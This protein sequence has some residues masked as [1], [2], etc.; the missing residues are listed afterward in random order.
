MMN[1]VIENWMTIT[2]NNSYDQKGQGKKNCTI[3]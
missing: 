1:G 3:I 2:E